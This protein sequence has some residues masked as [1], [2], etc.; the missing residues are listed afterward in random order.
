MFEAKGPKGAAGTSGNRTG[1]LPCL[2]IAVAG[3]ICRST[4]TSSLH[5]S[6]QPAS[7]YCTSKMSASTS[8]SYTACVLK[9]PKE[10]TVVSSSFLA[11]PPSSWLISSS[12]LRK[13]F[14][15]LAKLMQHLYVTLSLSCPIYRD[16]PRP[17]RPSQEKR[18]TT[19]PAPGSATIR[20]LATGLCGSD[21]HY[22]IHA[23]HLALPRFD[24]L[25]HSRPAG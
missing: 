22:Y 8:K 13:L 18:M 15:A 7:F 11:F 19:P 2:K 23:S 1:R 10:M 25:T 4:T 12:D 5:L 3:S 6:Y 21:N 14:I 16:V 24:T 9:G 17:F 20:I